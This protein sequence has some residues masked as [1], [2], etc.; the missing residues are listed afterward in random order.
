MNLNLRKTVFM[1]FTRKKVPT[2]IAYVIS[3][4]SLCQATEYKYLGVYF[5]C[6]LDWQ[7]HVDYVAAKAGRALGFLRRNARDYSLESRDLLYK[8]NVRSILEYACTVWGPPTIRDKQKLERLQNL[9]ARF[10]SGK[11]GVGFSATGTKELKWDLLETRRRKLRLKLFHAI[12]HCQ[13]CIVK[14]KYLL[15]PHYTS[16]RTD[17]PLKVREYF[18]KTNSFRSSFFPQTIRDWNSLPFD[19]VSVMSNDSFFSMLV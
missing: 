19:I 14:E 9:A 7:R 5:T 18:C 6:N 8:A 16:Q 2:E 12:Y 10:V 15:P 4:E 11:W 1:R 13:T 17:H 3:N